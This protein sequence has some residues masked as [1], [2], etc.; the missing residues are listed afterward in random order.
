MYVD[1]TTLHPASLSITEH[2][3]IRKFQS[4]KTRSF[5]QTPHGQNLSIFKS[6]SGQLAKP[7]LGRPLALENLRAPTCP[8]PLS[9][10]STHMSVLVDSVGPPS[11]EVCGAA[12][13]FP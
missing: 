9:L 8:P 5:H 3:P 4:F 12:A 11:A 2:N 10:M 13:S 1:Q 7:F 6:I